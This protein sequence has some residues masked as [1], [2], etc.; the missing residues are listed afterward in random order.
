[1]ADVSLHYRS[2]APLAGTFEVLGRIL[3]TW[4]RRAHERRELAYLDARTIRDLG[5]S[6]GEIQFEAS[7]PFWRS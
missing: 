3:A 4:R 7:K 5:L 1:M 6:T 2:Q